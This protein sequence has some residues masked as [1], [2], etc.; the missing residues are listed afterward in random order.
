MEGGKKREKSLKNSS[1]K[2]QR[3]KDKIVNLPIRVKKTGRKIIRE[4]RAS[5]KTKTAEG[6]EKEIME[7]IEQVKKRAVDRTRYEKELA[8]ARNMSAKAEQ[9]K[10]LIMW[11]GVT[12]F[13]ALIVVFWL[14]QVKINFQELK[15]K[16]SMENNLSEWNEA[17]DDIWQKMK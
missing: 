1:R 10:I 14:Y 17:A 6:R 3:K 9:H 12:F 11:S 7:E 15:T 2:S 16:N 13:M 5:E 4:E 8:E